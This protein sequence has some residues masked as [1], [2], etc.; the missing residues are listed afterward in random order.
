MYLAVVPASQPSTYPVE[1]NTALACPGGKS[2]SSDATTCVCAPG[3]ETSQQQ[4]SGCSAGSY[5]AYA[6]PGVCIAC[7]LGASSPIAASACV[8]VFGSGGNSTDASG[9][10]QQ[11]I[12]IIA[13]GVAGGVAG[14]GLLVWGLM[15][16]AA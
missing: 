8:G 16:I 14:V 12:Y 1:N 3:F 11:Q 10:S 7:P 2:P 5:K 6:G 4:C 15:A 13:G 9:L